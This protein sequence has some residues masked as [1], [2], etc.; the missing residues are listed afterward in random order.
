[1]S[2]YQVI[3]R[4]YRPQ[5]FADVIGQDP[6]VTTLKNAIRQNRIAHAYLFSG[7]RGTGKTT[8]ARLFAKA[9]NCPNLSP[10]QE[11]CGVCQTCREIALGTSLDVMEIDGASNR[12]IDDIRKINENVGYATAAARYKIYIIDEVHM[13][14]KEAFN[15]LLKTLEEPPPKV[16]FF[17]AT[18]EPHKVLPTII[19]R[20]QRF[21]LQRFSSQK[22]KE[23]LVSISKDL[24]IQ[25]D[26]D[27]LDIIAK[28]SEGGLRDAESLLDQIISFHEGSIDRKAVADVLGIMP[29]DV[30]FDLDRAGKEGRFVKA[31]EIVHTLFSEGK[32][33]QH[34]VE[35]LTEHYRN[36]LLLKLSPETPGLLEIE[37][38]MEKNYLEATALYSK[39]Q[40]L[41]ILDYLFKH[42]QM[43][44]EAP[45]LKVALEALLIR[46][47]RTHKSLPIETLVKRLIELEES[48]KSRA[49]P[50]T[51]KPEELRP[52]PE[53]QTPANS[54]KDSEAPVAPT[55]QT[56]SFKD[57]M[58]APLKTVSREQN[59]A[60][61]AE[62]E[63]PKERP[64]PQ[65]CAAPP[66]PPL[67]EQELQ[68]TPKEREQQITEP[69][70][71]YEVDMIASLDEKAMPEA[72]N[73][74][75]KGMT[76]PASSDRMPVSA[77]DANHL[78]TLLQFASV[79]LEGR[80]KRTH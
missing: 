60:N 72:L 24:Q 9:L 36:L 42:Q 11:P 7:S 71:A 28:R 40:L 6:I 67:P 26:D 13:L 5:K 45:S 25:I 47:M 77:K 70:R 37:A 54:P 75:V 63:P 58:S 57:E 12:G 41:D 76:G 16:K 19:S 30:L 80:L 21:S 23:K 27:A 52:L 22:I 4:K 49:I 10:D 35:M 33:L 2:E 65:E 79:E 68:E 69:T 20:C 55:T 1:M 74:G 48:V 66:P 29:K 3:S 73:E 39:E 62:T 50:E 59:R 31:Y 64:E 17:F 61:V 15:A 18:T 34:F 46:I 51:Q 14:T 56:S 53:A 32:D 38:S 44:R 43:A 78:D 8:L